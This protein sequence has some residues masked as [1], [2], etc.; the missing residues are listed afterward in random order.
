MVYKILIILIAVSIAIT[1]LGI[2]IINNKNKDNQNTSDNSGKEQEEESLTSKLSF[3]E[4][5]TLLGSDLIEENKIS[6]NNN[7]HTIDGT[8]ETF[9]NLTSNLKPVNTSI[10]YILPD[11]LKAG[12][13]TSLNIAKSDIQLNNSK[14]EELSQKTNN[15]TELA[16]DLIKNISSL[17]SSLKSELNDID[18]EFEETIKNLCLPLLLEENELAGQEYDKR[19]R[20][21][22]EYNKLIEE[23]KEEVNN[24][25]ELLNGFFPNISN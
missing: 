15:L 17:L 2:M 4:A 14:Y 1:L 16:S 12:N 7:L 5:Q 22:M 8:Q 20:R 18:A 10:N 3:E 13:T 24:Y 9:K 6:L 23:Y 25:N 19:R 11:Y 21:R